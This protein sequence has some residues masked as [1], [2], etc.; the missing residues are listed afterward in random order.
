MIFNY[1]SDASNRPIAWNITKQRDSVF[2]ILRASHID[3]RSIA[4]KRIRYRNF[5]ES[6]TI[7]YIHIR[8]RQVGVVI[9]GKNDQY[10]IPIDASLPKQGKDQ[11]EK[12]EIEEKNLKTGEIKS[13]INLKNLRTS[14]QIY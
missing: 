5:S 11:Y 3:S 9:W 14:L 10:F 8:L 12:A 4:G 2:R 1:L 6:L 13:F 7:V